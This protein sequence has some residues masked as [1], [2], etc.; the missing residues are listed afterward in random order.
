MRKPVPLLGEPAEEYQARLTAW[1][2]S[3]KSLRDTKRNRGGKRDAV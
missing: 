1:K 3:Q 2:K